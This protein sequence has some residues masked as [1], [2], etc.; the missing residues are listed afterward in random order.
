MKH[1]RWMRTKPRHDWRKPMKLR[2]GKYKP[3]T[4]DSI[5]LT[6][7]NRV[8]I[9]RGNT[10]LRAMTPATKRPTMP[11]TATMRPGQLPREWRP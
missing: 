5:A 11:I 6:P 9:A 10:N 1:V 4:T 7:D 3:S 8:V 2:G